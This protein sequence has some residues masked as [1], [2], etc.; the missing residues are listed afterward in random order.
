MSAFRLVLEA[1]ISSGYRDLLSLHSS[2]SADPSQIGKFLSDDS[3]RAFF[4][5]KFPTCVDNLLRFLGYN[6]TLCSVRGRG[7]GTQSIACEAI[8]L[9]VS[10]LSF[11]E[12]DLV[13][14][15]ARAKLVAGIL[16]SVLPYQ[17]YSLKALAEELAKKPGLLECIASSEDGAQAIKDLFS[18]HFV[19]KLPS[20]SYTW[21]DKLSALC[22]LCDGIPTLHGIPAQIDR[23]RTSRGLVGDAALVDELLATLPCRPCYELSKDPQAL[24][25]K[26]KQAPRDLA[27]SGCSDYTAPPASETADIFGGEIGL[28]KVFLSAKALKDIRK[29]MPSGMYLPMH[30]RRIRRNAE[31]PRVYGYSRRPIAP[32]SLW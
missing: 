3:S 31:L 14:H 2:V 23:W 27:D 30:H 18:V 13:G 20:I 32:T 26:G 6:A 28:W 21:A 22:C 11:P 29:H 10:V 12:F 5:E 16:T 19:K 7:S 8:F 17:P 24:I 15:V 25:E 4:F 1:G 9:A